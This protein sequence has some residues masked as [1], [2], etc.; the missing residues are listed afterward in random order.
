[1]CQVTDIVFV[2]VKKLLKSLIKI[3]DYNTIMN[4]FIGMELR[5]TF[6]FAS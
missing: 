6:L 5:E 1:M 4:I 3:N 2:S